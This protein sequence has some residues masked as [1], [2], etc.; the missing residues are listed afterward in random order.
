[1]PDPIEVMTKA[2]LARPKIYEF[3]GNPTPQAV[4]AFEDLQRDALGGGE[5]T[6]GVQNASL[7]VLAAS[8]VLIGERVLTESAAISLTDG[9]A[10]GAL[11]I[12]LADTA[13]TPNTYGSASATVSFTVDQKGRI[14]SANAFSLNTDNITEGAKLFYTD[15]RAR[16]SLAAGTGLTYSAVTGEFTVNAAL[17]AL[18]AVSG[19]VSGTFASPTSI[20]VQNGLIVAIS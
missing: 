19:P 5:F 3:M 14:T 13:V 2:V 12:D 16:A 15:T 6:T 11:T 7:L 20:T 8:D 4:K 1:M 17:A 9:G 18:A 10:G